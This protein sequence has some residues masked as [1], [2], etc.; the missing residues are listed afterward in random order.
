MMET[1]AMSTEQRIEALQDEITTVSATLQAATYKL[2]TLI[3]ELDATG[4][5][6]RC[7]RTDSSRAPRRSQT[8]SGWAGASARCPRG[9]SREVIEPPP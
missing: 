2:I 1:S 9:R 4:G 3:G 5:P 8:T 7:P 6:I